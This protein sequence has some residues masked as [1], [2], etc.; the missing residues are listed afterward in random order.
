VYVVQVKCLVLV[1]GLA[2]CDLSQ[3]T[4]ASRPEKF[5]YI[6][7]T[8]LAPSCGTAECHSALKAQSGDVFDSVE[9]ARA[10]LDDPL[11]T[12]LVMSCATLSPPETS[13]CGKDAANGSYLFTVLEQ[14]QGVISDVGHGDVMPLDQ[15]LPS[16]DREFIGQWI[17]DG[18]EGYDVKGPPK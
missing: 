8:I 10:T 7:E 9:G 6:V 3:K 17:D 2:A 11:H 13:P 14:G 18:A 15:A 12:D 16:A 4:A 5:D 1:M